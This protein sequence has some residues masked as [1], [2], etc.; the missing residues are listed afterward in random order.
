MFQKVQCETSAAG[1][2]TTHDHD[3]DHDDHDGGRNKSSSSSDELCHETIIRY[4]RYIQNKKKPQPYTIS[5]FSPRST[6]STG[7]AWERCNKFVI[8]YAVHIRE[9]RANIIH[10]RCV[11]GTRCGIGCD[12]SVTE[13]HNCNH[14]PIPSN[15]DMVCPRLYARQFDYFLRYPHKRFRKSVVSTIFFNPA[16]SGLHTLYSGFSFRRTVKIT[17]SVVW[18]Y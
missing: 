8:S 12:Y 9:P 7:R 1:A 5:W 2:Q 11:Q 18:R 3:H 16:G 10:V 17:P 15:L 6:V 14:T 4:S 13:P